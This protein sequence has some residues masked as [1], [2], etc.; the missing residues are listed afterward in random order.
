[1]IENPALDLSALAPA[2]GG[3][4]P[5]LDAAHIYWSGQS[6]GGMM[7][8]ITTAVEPDLRASAVDVP[9]GAFVELIATGSAKMHAIVGTLASATFGIRGDEPVDEFH[10]GVQLMAMATEPG[11]PIDYAPHVFGSSLFDPPPP[12]RPSLLLGYSVDDEVMPNIATHAL[13]GAFG[14]PLV[15]PTIRDI[16]GV[17]AV[18]APLSANFGDRTGAAVQY[19]PNTHGLG[20]NRYDTRQY[21]PGDPQLDPANRWPVIKH[22]IT[23]ELPIREHIAALVHFFE[24]DLAGKPPEAI[25]TAPPV[26]DYDGDGVPD[27]TE[28][29]NGTDPYDPA[30]H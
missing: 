26:D 27:A 21:L 28:T 22:P 13:I 2:L 7:G 9:G 18:D 3:T 25:V 11:D 8:S 24:T 14:I 29:A 5:K 4:T 19:S 10:P 30:S 17:Q 16:A 12:R 23:I 1:M 20:S 6:L 15:K